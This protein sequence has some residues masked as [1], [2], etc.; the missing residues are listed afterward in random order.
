MLNFKT[1]FHIGLGLTICI[2]TE[3]A[4][5]G[6]DIY[7]KKA[8][9]S[10]KTSIL[11]WVNESLSILKSDEFNSN[12]LSLEKIYP[13]VWLSEKEKTSNLLQLMFIL[14]ETDPNRLDAKYLKTGII[15]KGRSKK[16]ITR[17]I[18]YRGNTFASVGPH[19]KRKSLPLKMRIGRVHL[20]RY[21]TGD[22]VEKSCAINTMAHEISHTLS[23]S[24]SNLQSYFLDIP[25]G[26]APAGV[27]SAS[28]FVGTVAQ[29]T[30]LQNKGRI[31]NTQFETCV[32]LFVSQ[33]F[34]SVKCN[35]FP[36]G[37]TIQ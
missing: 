36:E 10:E 35:D 1:L 16:D 30:Y 21:L 19:S 28:Y 20:D 12:L 17:N 31:D 14:A 34:P 9:E 33:P 18:G 8:K 11:A 5:A 26:L 32:K 6:P 25:A 13:E 24:S 2:L 27:P 37:T 22:T 23:I 29:C 4:Y 15:M 7:I 3:P